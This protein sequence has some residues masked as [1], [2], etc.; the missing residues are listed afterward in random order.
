MPRSRVMKKRLSHPSA[1]TSATT[2]RDRAGRYGRYLGYSG[3]VFLAG[4]LFWVNASH[5]SRAAH[6]P[7]AQGLRVS[8]GGPADATRVLPATLFPDPRVKE[9]Y[10]IAALIPATLNKLYCWCGC[11]ERGMRSNLECFESEHAAQCDVCMAGAEVAW[12]MR[13]KG[14]TDAATIQRALDARFAP[15]RT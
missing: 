13:G 8:N 2:L 9:A 3:L 12:A 6:P 7:N 5:R 4:G 10:R 1:P 14:V 11:I 15:R